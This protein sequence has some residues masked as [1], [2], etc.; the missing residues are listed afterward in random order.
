MDGPVRALKGFVIAVIASCSIYDSS[1]L[2]G[3]SPD[4][5][6]ADS[7][8]DVDPCDHAEPPSRPATDDPSDAGGATYVLALS[9]VDFDL[10][11]D[12]GKPPVGLDLDHT[13]TCPAP[14]SCVPA[15]NAG[16]QCDD[17]RG[18]DNAGGTLIKNFSQLTSSELN[19][20]KVNSNIGKGVNSMI[21]VLANYNETPNDTNVS[22][23][24]LVSNGTVP[25]DDAG[26]NPIPQHD[27]KDQWGIDPSSLVGSAPPYVAVNEDDAAY[28]T[29][30]VLVAHVSFPFG[31]GPSVGANFL[32]VDGAY[33]IGTLT[34]TATGYALVGYV[35]GRWD[36]R[37]I[38][39]GM[40]GM[41]DPFNAGQFL[42]GSDSTYQ[43]LKA[44]I[45]AGSDIAR[46]STSDN[47]NA[48][49]GALSLAV[50]VTAEPAQ[51][52]GVLP[53]NPR[54][55]PCG[56]TYSDQCGN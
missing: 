16:P 47:T 20:N 12:G 51:L 36:T 29:N 13:C 49:C 41:H 40:A 1:L 19:A 39:T 42:C 48:P 23:G 32:R 28:V 14:T 27:G 31:L 10:T 33:L 26:T 5:V 3:G 38:L 8:A 35:T 44:A 30:G 25:L 4:V 43:A 55:T 22:L 46:D 9:N 17:S 34:K 15:T 7:G 45:C 52:G 56:Q 21:L 54:P 53:G 6:V 24:V 50:G 2:V 37:N 11:G 18:R